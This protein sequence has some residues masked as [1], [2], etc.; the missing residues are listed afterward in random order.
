M[1]ITINDLLEAG[2]HFGH[3]TKRWNPKMKPYI[4]GARNGISIF[5]LTVTVRLLADACTF[6]R[7]LVADGGTVLFVGAKRQAQ[8]VVREAAERT[9]MPYMCDRWLGG[10]MTNFEVVRRRVEH[11]KELQQMQTDGTLEK[12]PK[13]EQ[14]R[15]RREFDKMNKTLGGI[16]NLNDLPDAI[17]IV[18][19]IHEEIA[20]REANR[21]HVPVVAIVDSNGNPDNIE[22]VVPGNDDAFRAI[23]VLLDGFAAAILEGKL[24]V[25]RREPVA[26]PATVPDKDEM[27]AEEAAPAQAPA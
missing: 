15:I 4:Y 8:E 11:L 14:A 16:V 10:T 20:V 6:L 3:Q 1:A 13:K 18:D 27:P 24:Q 2:V 23:K 5:D 21:L 9:G 22:K 17:I 26:A 7:D 12:R 25:A 19:V